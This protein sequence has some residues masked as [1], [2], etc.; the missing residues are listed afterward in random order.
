MKLEEALAM[1]RAAKTRG[2]FL[3]AL[4]DIRRT[5]AEMD[6]KQCT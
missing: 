3:S 2:E 1:L 5:L 4:A 6:E